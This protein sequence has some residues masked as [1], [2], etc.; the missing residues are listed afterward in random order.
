MSHHYGDWLSALEKARM[1]RRN[2]TDAERLL[3][4]RLRNGRLEGLKFRRQHVVGRWIADFACVGSKLIVEVDGSSHS[5]PS[6]D[7]HRDDELTRL[8]WRVLRVSDGEVI[9]EL[10]EVFLLI[11]DAARHSS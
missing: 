7:C 3:W 9:R 4:S 10:D 1:L 11:A 5:D 6:R 2:S 8:G